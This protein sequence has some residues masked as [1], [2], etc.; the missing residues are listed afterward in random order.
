MAFK[1]RSEDVGK[2]RRGAIGSA[3]SLSQLHIRVLAPTRISSYYG[4][5][6][7]FIP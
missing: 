6:C 2:G 7:S 3:L 5:F 4:F 1:L